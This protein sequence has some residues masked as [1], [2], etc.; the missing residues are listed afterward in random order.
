MSL[1]IVKKIVKA[2]DDKR[3]TIFRLLKLKSLQL[4]Q[5]TL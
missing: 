3:V 1:D 4:L 2:L 5:I